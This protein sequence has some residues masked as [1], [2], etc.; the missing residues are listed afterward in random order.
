M[1]NTSL[2]HLVPCT[3]GISPAV[4]D[5]DTRITVSDSTTVFRYSA[6]LNDLP[7]RHDWPLAK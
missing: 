3:H 7:F 2:S 5:T 6:Q 1:S 4:V